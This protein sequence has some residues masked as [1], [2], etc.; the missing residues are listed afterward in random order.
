MGRRPFVA[1]RAVALL[2]LAACSSAGT[3]TVPAMRSASAAAPLAGSTFYVANYYVSSVAAFE[4]GKNTPSRTITNG[5]AFPN[6]LAVDSSGRLYVGNYGRATGSLSS[7]VAVYSS[8]GNQPSRVITAGIWGPYAMAVHA[9]NLYVANNGNDTITIYKAGASQPATTLSHGIRGPESLAFDGSGNLYVANNADNS[10]TRY[11]KGKLSPQLRLTVGIAGPTSVL[12]SSGGKVFV[13]NQRGSTVAVFNPAFPKHPQH[14]SQHV[15]K[16]IAMAFS[17]G[18]LFVLNLGDNTLVKYDETTLK[19]LAEST[20]GIACPSGLSVDAAGD[21]FVSNTC[22]SSISVF[23]S[24]T[25]N[26]TQ[27]ITKGVN[28]PS[29]ISAGP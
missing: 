25:L 15:N 11:E 28:S 20:S 14:I 10:V 13:A 19:R 26:L 18:A 27:R 9:G 29:A 12:V 17:G 3:G 4:V 5:V 21:L 1:L 2:A 16:P 6:S 23:G 24:A 22:P 8:N 7:S